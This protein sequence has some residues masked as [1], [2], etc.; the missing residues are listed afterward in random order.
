DVCEQCTSRGL[1]LSAAVLGQSRMPRL[2]LRP[3]RNAPLRLSVT[4]EIDNCFLGVR[5]LSI[6]HL[7]HSRSSCGE[8][9]G[10][11]ATN[12]RASSTICS[13][14]LARVFAWYSLLV[15][16]PTCRRFASSLAN[17]SAVS[18]T[19]ESGDDTEPPSGSG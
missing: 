15:M 7:R 4:D 5:S 2:N 19:V 12:A 16:A 6:R 17:C 1:G 8:P 14:T 11:V 13:A 18:S 10:S 9:C 3:L